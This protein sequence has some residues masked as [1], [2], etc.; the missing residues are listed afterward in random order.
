MTHR[1]FRFKLMPTSA[2]A[3]MF[4]QTSGVVRLVYNLALE[5]RRDWYRQFERVTGRHLNYVAQARELTRL[6]A[7]FEWIAAV[8]Q[9]SQQQALRDLDKAFTNFFRGRCS[10]PMHRKRGVNDAFRFQGREVSVETINRKWARAR[11]PKIGWVKFRSTRALRGKVESV[12]ISPA[13]DGWHISFVCQLSLE[14]VDNANPSVGIDRGVKSSVMLS[15]GERFD[16]P[17]A[18][19]AADKKYRRAQR[20]LSRKAIGSA[21]RARAKHRCAELSARRMRARRDWLHKVSL[22]VAARFGTVVLEDLRVTNMTRAAH[23]DGARR[24]AGLNRSILEQGWNIFENI[25]FYKLEERGGTLVKVN[26]AYTSQTCSECGVIAKESRESQ[27]RFACRHC[28]FRAN[29]DHNAAINILRRN[30]PL[31]RMEEADCRADEVR[32]SQGFTALANPAAIAA[33]GC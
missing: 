20:A 2:Q 29:A 4:R 31:R 15:T 25:L 13:V 30:T 23:G 24:K 6:R 5:Q 8:S 16:L 3:E 14:T 27:A 28:G 1:S 26:P 33:G 7:E 32:T 11:L 10:F 21:R 12:I 9:T 17:C 18:V 22:S 19:R